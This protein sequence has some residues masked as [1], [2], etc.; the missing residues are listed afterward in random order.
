MRILTIYALFLGMALTLA[1]AQE[2]P[3]GVQVFGETSQ[4]IANDRASFQITL[5]AKA[6]SP[7]EARDLLATQANKLAQILADF[8][9][10]EKTQTLS[11][12]SIPIYRHTQ[13]NPPQI[14]GYQASSTTITECPADSAGDLAAILLETNPQQLNGPNFHLSEK[15]R[16]SKEIEL[17]KDATINAKEKAE[18]IAS[19][20]NMILGN[21]IFLGTETSWGGPPRQIPMMTMA[22]TADTE[23]NGA[24]VISTQAGEG[25]LQ[26]TV[27]G[28]FEL[29]PPRR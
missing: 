9:K 12:T 20:S 17:L 26:T 21:A 13:N 11:I 23:S 5:E 15:L 8:G 6:N 18:A 14:T 25:R 22:R 2:Q 28:R 19:A 1:N 29:L 24:E 3:T 4:E 10:A 16:K 7:K 27:N